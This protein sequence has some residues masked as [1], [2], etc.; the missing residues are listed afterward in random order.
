MKL[1]E[2]IKAQKVQSPLASSVERMELLATLKKRRV[3][4]PSP[5]STTDTLLFAYEAHQMGDAMPNFDLGPPLMI[6]V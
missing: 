1:L 5:Q 6:E 3:C 4:P 2:E